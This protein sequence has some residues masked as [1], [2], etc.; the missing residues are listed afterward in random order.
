MSKVLVHE[1]LPAS[2]EE[3]ILGHGPQ[4]K[5]SC[6]HSQMSSHLSLPFLFIHYLIT[7]LAQEESLE[8]RR[9]SLAQLPLEKL[10]HVKQTLNSKYSHNKGD[11]AELGGEEETALPYRTEPDRRRA[12]GPTRRGDPWSH[13]KEGKGKDVSSIFQSTVTVLSFLAFG[14]YLLC[15]LCQSLKNTQ[16]NQIPITV[17][18]TVAPAAII[19]G[20]RRRKR[21]STEESMIRTLH[22]IAEGYAAYSLNHTQLKQ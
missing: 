15:L 6:H 16:V 21:R 5:Q 11:T 19:S 17:M 22:L 10:L 14:G 2:G 20:K 7:T 12:N 9:T 13:E 18:P 8:A 1:E 3:R 4:H